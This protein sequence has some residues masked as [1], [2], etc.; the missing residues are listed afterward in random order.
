MVALPEPAGVAW[1]S[2]PGAG[3]ELPQLPA[4]AL[5]PL[6]AP[7][8]GI[9]VPQ[10]LVPSK[11]EITNTAMLV[12][13]LRREVRCLYAERRMAGSSRYDENMDTWPKTMQSSTHGVAEGP[14]ASGRGSTRSV[15]R[16][17][18]AGRRGRRLRSRAGTPRAV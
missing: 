2:W 7:L 8:T 14:G 11:T 1:K 6:V 15:T 3:L 16:D 12:V 18:G 9:S 4:S 10:G 5:V 13:F 17:G